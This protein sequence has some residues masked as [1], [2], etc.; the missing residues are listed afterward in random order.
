MMYLYFLNKKGEENEMVGFSHNVHATFTPVDIY[1]QSSC[2]CS[3]QGS[4]LLKIDGNFSSLLI[5]IIPSR[6]M[7]SSQLRIRFQVNANYFL[8]VLQLK[9]AQFPAI[10]SYNLVLNNGSLLPY[11]ASPCQ[12]GINTI[13]LML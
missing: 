13:Q 5:C 8:Y 3:S 11:N 4:K 7:K 10:W 1:R 2:Y 9:H 6:N 12:V